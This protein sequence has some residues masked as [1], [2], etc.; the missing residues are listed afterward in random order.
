[1]KIHYPFG[2]PPA[3][4]DCLWRAEAKRYSYIIDADADRYG[5]TDAKLELLW[6]QVKKRT[7]CGAWIDGKF[8][9][10]N[11][12]KRWACNTETEAIESFRAR[13]QRQIEILSHQLNR[14][15]QDLALI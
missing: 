15:K 8:V 3:D 1:M 4:I 11:A 13:K 9:N 2:K 7:K 14:A 12:R 10:L 5:V 6:Y